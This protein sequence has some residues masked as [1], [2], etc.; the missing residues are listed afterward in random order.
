[1]RAPDDP[2]AA[3][4]AVAAAEQRRLDAASD[5]RAAD[6]SARDAD[7]AYADAAAAAD[8]ALRAYRAALQR[9]SLSPEVHDP[10]G[11]GEQ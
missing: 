9:V 10:A 3:L 11:E 2:D 7:R 8:R 4:A 1:M 5:K 6:Q